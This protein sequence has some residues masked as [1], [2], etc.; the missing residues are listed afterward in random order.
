MAA[1]TLANG[2]A[3]TAAAPKSPCQV[4]GSEKLPAETGGIAGICSVIERTIAAQAPNVAYSVKVE[5]VS[6]SKLTA[7]LIVRGKTL[8]EQRFAVMDRRLNAS[9]IE[10]FANGLATEVAKAADA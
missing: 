6:A 7:T 5:V 1:I 2:K 4:I 9:A 10:H 8:P 3:V